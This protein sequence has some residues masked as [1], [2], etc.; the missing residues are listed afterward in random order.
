MQ[1]ET[2]KVFCD[3]VESRSFSQSAVRNFVTQSAVSQQIRNL[4]LRLETTLLIRSGKS[5]IPTE[6]GQL[7]YE[8]SR[9][10]LERFDR[11]QRQLKSAGEEMAGSL[12]VATIYSVGIYEMSLAIRTFLKRYPKVNLHVEFSRSAR[13]YED[14]LNGSIDLG[15]VTYPRPR[16]G[17]QI[18]SLP[19]DRLTLICSPD[20]P[21]ARRRHIELRKIDGEDFIAFM[22]NIPSRQAIDR[23]LKDNNASVRVVMEFDNI[24][25]IKRSVEIGTGISIVPLMSVQREVQAG[26]LAQLQFSDQNFF[27]TLGVLVKRNRPQAPAAQKFI[28]LLQQSQHHQPDKAMT[29]RDEALRRR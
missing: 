12:R 9:D 7:L 28:E 14:C 4:E 18:I 6:A 26:S 5:V 27:R 20:H 13:V 25:T 23:I 1:I 22:E 17:L 11:L 15:I 19:A 29:P 10:I 16:K 3:L 2:L 24:E 8:A 21:F